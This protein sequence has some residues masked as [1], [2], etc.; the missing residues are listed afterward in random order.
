MQANCPNQA[1]AGNGCRT[2]C[3]QPNIWNLACRIEHCGF[4]AGDPGT[5]CPHAGG[6][7]VCL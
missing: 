4:A 3:S 2:T 6:V 7:S 5:H 1:P